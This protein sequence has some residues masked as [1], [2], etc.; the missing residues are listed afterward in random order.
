MLI[1]RCCSKP[2][3]FISIRISHDFS[4]TAALMEN[5]DFVI[6]VDTSVAH[7]AGA[8][9]K[10]VWV[11]LLKFRLPLLLDREDSPWYASA[12]LIDKTIKVSGVMF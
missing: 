5:L 4:D 10:E 12:R 8:L 1:L 2:S 6:T 11:L 9:G 7:L 3:T